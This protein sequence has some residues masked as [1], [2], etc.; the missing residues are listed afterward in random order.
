MTR[1]R[2]DLRARLDPTGTRILC[3]ACDA[4]LGRIVST[5]WGARTPLLP[6]TFGAHVSRVPLSSGTAEVVGPWRQTNRSIAAQHRDAPDHPLT[7]RPV[8]G[9]REDRPPDGYIPARDSR[10]ECPGCGKEQRID[11]GALR[12]EC[13]RTAL[14]PLDQT[15]W[16]DDA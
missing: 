11:D 5:Q 13:D 16:R 12:V 2:A 10:I 8:G 9:P 3:G 6:L 7:R 4:Q 14:S 15:A 1:R